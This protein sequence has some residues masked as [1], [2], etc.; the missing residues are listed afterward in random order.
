MPKNVI[1][2]AL[3]VAQETG[4]VVQWLRA[5]GDLVTQSE[6]L[7]E[8]ETDK[9]TVE[10]EALATGVLRHVTAKAGDDVPVGTVIAEIW[11][12]S[13]ADEVGPE[14]PS[15][16]ELPTQQSSA[17]KNPQ[18]AAR[19]EMVREPDLTQK[20]SQGTNPESS[21]QGRVAA[22]PKARRLAAERGI[23]LSSLGGG[24]SQP[25]VASD[26]SR[27][28]DLLQGP[29]ATK[30]KG[31]DNTET[32]RIWRIMA[33]RTAEAWRTIPHFYLVREVDAGALV[34]WR[35]ELLSRLPQKITITDL[36]I[37]KVATCLQQHP[38]L[39]SQWR[40]G[41]VQRQ[42]EIN[43]GLAVGLDQGII[44]P[45]IHKADQL[46]VQ[47]IAAERSRLVHQAQTEKLRPNDISGGTFTIS[48]LG[49]Y[50]VDSFQAIVNPPQAAILAVGR[51]AQRFVPVDKQPVLK[52][53]MTLSISCDHRVVDGVCAAKFLAALA[54]SL[55]QATPGSR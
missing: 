4:R 23:D 44:V 16:I 32:G 13:E 15:V 37:K 50:G 17:P 9:T 20:A 26:L 38:R 49:M 40:D 28:S 36:L 14:K 34:G 55:E 46:T 25:I 7:L 3:G 45:V 10:L 47:E 51:I 5:E 52:P 27:A 18:A 33:D 24:S 21:P 1:M 53:T 42:S 22:S 31:Q 19:P 54:E 29:A 12:D 2:P 39:N 43:I 6:P 11:G 30:D 41:N 48:N 8:I 35:E